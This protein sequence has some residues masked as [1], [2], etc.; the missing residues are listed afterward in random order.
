M[1]VEIIVEGTMQGDRSEI[2]GVDL[3]DATALLARS[4]VCGQQC[5]L[6]RRGL[7]MILREARYDRYKTADQGQNFRIQRRIPKFT[8]DGRKYR[9]LRPI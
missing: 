5:Q 4:V 6:L 1:L 9:G 2:G 7:E 3:V 8:L